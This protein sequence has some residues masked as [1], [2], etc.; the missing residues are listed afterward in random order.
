METI[1]FIIAIAFSSIYFSYLKSIFMSFKEDM[2]VKLTA[3]GENNATIAENTETIKANNENIQADI[4]NLKSKIDALPTGEVL[5]EEDKQILL[6]AVNSAS[7]T[8][9]SNLA[10][11]DAIVAK[12]AEI[13]AIVP[14][15]L[16]D[17]PDTS[18]EPGT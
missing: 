8:V 14:E 9:E 15:V 2:L 6:D 5:T 3:I 12:T 18:G 4:L 7:I 16:M 11:S 10:A 17:E 13:A 1:L